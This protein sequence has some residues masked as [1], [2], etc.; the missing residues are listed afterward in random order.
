[1]F[2]P[3]DSD[4]SARLESWQSRRLDLSLNGLGH[5]PL[6]L[7]LPLELASAGS[8]ADF[9]SSRVNRRGLSPG[10]QTRA[11]AAHPRPTSPLDRHGAARREVIS[12]VPQ[13]TSRIVTGGA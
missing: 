8:V 2:E 10:Q 11:A 6:W 12:P 3:P 9:I 7:R 5:F 13:P 1:V 4:E